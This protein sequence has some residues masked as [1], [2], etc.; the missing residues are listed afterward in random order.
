MSINSTQTVNRTAFKELDAPAAC[1][2]R[3]EAAALAT[4]AAVSGN[5]ISVFV[6][7]TFRDGADVGKNV[8]GGGFATDASTTNPKVFIV[9]GAHGTVMAHELGHAMGH[10]SCLGRSGHAPANTVMVP[11]GAHNTP[12]ADTSV[13]PIICTHVRGFSG[14]SGTG[15]TDCT[16]D[17]S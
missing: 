3:R 9:S 5:V 13:A 2:P 4:A 12:I 1:A 14:A 11:S 16:E 6:P 10:A 15:R 7:D 17:F 8:S